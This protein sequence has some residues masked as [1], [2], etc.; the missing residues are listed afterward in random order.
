MDATTYVQESEETAQIAANDLF[1]EIYQ[2]TQKHY[3]MC[4][5]L[6]KDATDYI[7]Y[8]IQKN[9]SDPFGYFYLSIKIHKSPL[10]TRPVC[11]DC[12][13]LIHPLGK[14]LD[15]ILQPIIAS[16]P[17]Y[18]KDS[19]T[20][21]QEINKPVLPLNASIITFNAV[22]M[23]T[24]IDIDDSISQIMEFLSTIWDENDC[25]AVEEAMIIVM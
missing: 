1:T 24:N 3:R 9:H 25:K 12:T 6:P 19:F 8:W 4:E 15:Q 14:W 18:F 13:S 10:S 2:W 17:F 5:Y 11:S 16:Q 21:K 22:A 20:L 7:W 23:Y